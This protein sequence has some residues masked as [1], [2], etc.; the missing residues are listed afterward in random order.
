MKTSYHTLDN[1]SHAVY[2]EKGSKFLAYARS[3]ENVE[4]VKKQLDDLKRTHRKAR[5][6]CYA[7]ILGAKGLE[8]RVYDDG[9]PNHSAGDPILGQLRSF[10]LTNTL[11]VVVRYF[12][13]T[14]LGIGGLSNA[15]REAAKRALES[16]KIVERELSQIWH[17]TFPHSCVNQVLSLVKELNLPILKKSIKDCCKL[18][19]QVPLTK[20]ELVRSRFVLVDDLE[21]ILE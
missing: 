2:K 21:L 1:M 5:H 8:Y 10:G 17:L 18:T 15:Y 3:V 14:K 11:V 19:L 7:Y 13:G 16:A 9:E 12:G 4:Q 20:T 6:Y